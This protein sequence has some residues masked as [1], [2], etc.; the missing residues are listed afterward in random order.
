MSRFC[1]ALVL[2]G[3][4]A[5]PTR[6]SSQ[7]SETAPEQHQRLQ[8][9]SIYQSGRSGVVKPA[10]AVVRDSASW[11]TWWDRIVANRGNKPPLPTVEFD[12]EMVVLV[13]SGRTRANGFKVSIDSVLV[14]NGRLV[15]YSTDVGPGSSCVSGST[16]NQP[17][18]VVRVPRHS[19]PA[20]F[21]TRSVRYECR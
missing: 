11:R 4:L 10:Q 18:A 5:F 13:A 16:S 17:V 7:V 8:L 21:V 19:E 9:D 20:R 2:I 15:V 6:G 3:L 12:R 14:G 1:R